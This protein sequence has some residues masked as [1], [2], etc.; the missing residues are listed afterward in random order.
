MVNKINA[1]KMVQPISS[2]K[3][4]VKFDTDALNAERAPNEGALVLVF[5][6][7]LV[8]S[9]NP[10]NDAL[11]LERNSAT[12]QAVTVKAITIKLNIIS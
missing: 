11:L 2:G 3:Q 9:W 7:G 12:K 6:L 5:A 4:C 8:G 1:G 10:T